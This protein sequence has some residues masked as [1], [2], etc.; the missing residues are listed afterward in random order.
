MN[1]T[2]WLCLMPHPYG[3]GDNQGR[4]IGALANGLRQLGERTD[5]LVLDE[6][7]DIT[8][9]EVQL[10]GSRQLSD[11][12]WWQAR[13]RGIFLTTFGTSLMQPFYRAARQAGWKV[14]VRMDCDG[15][16]G[17]SGG[18]AKYIRARIIET[19]DRNRRQKRDFSGTSSG[20]V[21]GFARGLAGVLFRSVVERR[22]GQSYELVDRLLVETPLACKSFHDHFERTRQNPLSERLSILPPAISERFSCPAGLQKKPIIIAVGQWWRMQKN[23]RL[24]V[25][26]MRRSLEQEND[27]RWIIAGD[28][29]QLVERR[30]RS[31]HPDLCWRVSF[32]NQL[33]P[34]ELAEHYMASRI[35][36][37]SSLQEGFPNTLCEALCSG[38]TFVGPRGIQAFEHCAK[39]GWG[40]TYAPGE[41]TKALVS[42]FRRQAGQHPT[43][44]EAIANKAQGVFHRRN[45][46]KMLVALDSG[47]SIDSSIWMGEEQEQIYSSREAWR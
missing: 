2:Q 28:G 20:I 16:P 46:A 8:D 15:V 36:F 30:F 33:S 39:L 45:V 12:A 4:D 23:M 35:T 25:Q 17:P 14:W 6:R 42:A 26:T 3:W 1:Q 38:T 47:K 29:T 43:A 21:E 34:I 41:A 19:V 7:T 44:Y 18:I 13:G 32:Y 5:F 31:K 22:L 40:I 27:M 11:P 10:A 24:L 37:F 9:P